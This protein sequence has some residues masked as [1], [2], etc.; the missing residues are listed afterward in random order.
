MSGDILLR[1]ELHNEEQARAILTSTAH[2]WIKDQLRQGR[3]L[4]LEARL[5][6]DAITEAQRGYLH[7]VVLTEA[8]LYGRS[9]GRQFEMKVWKEM[10]R[11]ELLGYK[12]VTYINPRTGRMRR[13]KERVSTEDLGVRGMAEYI[14]KVTAILATEFNVVV[15]EPLPAHLRP[16]R[17]KAKNETI[18]AD[19]VITETA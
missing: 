17:R 5:L 11:E 18:D 12:D 19:G 8:A 4:V 9:R 7:G 15:S 6:D 1:V 14:D 10:F 16:G 13:K 2:P 3:E